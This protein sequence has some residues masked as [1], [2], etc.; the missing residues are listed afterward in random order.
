MALPREEPG[1]LN[2]PGKPVYHVGSKLGFS[3]QKKSSG[4][5][6]QGLVVGSPASML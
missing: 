1:R 5:E 4:K 3:S 2:C 6:M